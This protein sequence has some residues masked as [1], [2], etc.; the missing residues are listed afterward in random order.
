[1][2]E[3]RL[4]SPH[5]DTARTVLRAG[6]PALAGLGLLFIIIG[7][8]SF[9]ASFGSFESPRYFW[10]AFLGIPLLFVGVLMCKFGYL[11]TI[12]RYVAA[13]AA[14]VVKDA[15]NYLGEGTQPG[16]KAVAKAAAEGVIEAQ[17]GAGPKA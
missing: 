9:F 12:S 7:L 16:V 17:K 3:N 10:C 14:P 6:G 13:E 15:A 2:D 4:K 11:G 8:V 1:M 5:H